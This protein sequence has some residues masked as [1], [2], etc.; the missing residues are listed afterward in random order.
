MFGRSACTSLI[1]CCLL[2]GMFNFVY[3]QQN[4]EWIDLSEEKLMRQEN[5]IIAEELF[6]EQ[7]DLLTF[8]L[9]L[10]GATLAQL[11]SCG[12]FT[13]FQ[14]QSLIQYR[15]AHGN[16]FSVYELASIEG[17]EGLAKQ[18]I[19]LTV[20]KA[21]PGSPVK[22][23]GGY[24]LFYTG[25]TF[26]NSDEHKAYPGSIWKSS[27]RIKKGMGKRLS[28]GLAYDKDP[29]EQ[30]FRGYRPEHINAYL[31]W[32]GKRSLEQLILG[33]FRIN[34]GMGLIHGAS[35][36]TSPEGIHSSPLLLSML[37][38]YA[39]ISESLLHQGAACKINISKLKLVAWASFQSIDLSLQDLPENVESADWSAHIRENAYHRTPSELLGRNLA[40]LGSAGIQLTASFGNLDLGVQYAPEFNCLS[41]G[42]RDSLQVH[43]VGRLYHASSIQWHWKIQKAVFYGEFAPGSGPS[44]A[45]LAGCRFIF[46]DFLRG[47][48][49]AHNY[50]VLRRETFSSAYAFGSHIK[51]ERGLMILFHAEPYRGIRSD[52][53][54]ELYTNPAPK[55]LSKVPSSGFRCVLTL[56]NGSHEKVQWRF[57]MVKTERQQ[58]PST[59]INSGIRP[60]THIQNNRVDGRVII[61]LFPGL[62]WQSRLVFSY[63]PR[64]R[65]MRGHAALQ[66]I[67]FR[68]KEELRFSS[69][70]VLYHIPSWEDRIYLYEPGLYQEFRFRPY[71]GTGHKISMLAS[72]HPL[73]KIVIEAKATLVHENIESKWEVAMQLR[74]KL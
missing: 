7:Q 18:A 62:I 32:K 37:K 49:Q 20:D 50:G 30:A 26:S 74:L 11:E 42:G 68:L 33:N 65:P 56:Q 23:T 12:L 72:F 38:P 41:P 66:Q 55:T 17:C 5:T 14:A 48:L 27:L 29:G 3:A 31:Q 39:G 45:F 70:F 2:P 19:Y 22:T 47:S 54:L 4:K 6:E 58:T 71:H 46:N 15:E 28:M 64:A 13:R 73:D 25:R 43:Q 61:K 9:N 16:L 67:T 69:Q 35:F 21:Q 10:N 57:R 8:P 36:M 1:L 34:T 24:V 51:N 60:L 40:Y 53:V 63:T 52:F 59:N 44:M